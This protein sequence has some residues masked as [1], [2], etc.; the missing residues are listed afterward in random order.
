MSDNTNASVTPRS[1]ELLSRHRCGLLVVDVQEKLLGSIEGGRRVVW[2]IGRLLDAARLMGVPIIGT[3]Q[4]PQGL[5]PTVEEL[6]DRVGACAVK[7]TFSC[8]GCAGLLD[9]WVERSIDQV[10]VVGIEAHVCVLQTVMDLMHAG[11]RVYVP[12]DAV[13][14]RS[15]Q[16]RETALRR[17]EG[18]GAT[19]V[20][21][22]SVMF[23]WCETSAA[24][25]FKA[26]SSL[27]RQLPPAD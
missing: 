13:G 1:P 23:E 21:T 5:G 4:Y 9:A 18:G 25:E 12:V 19:L 8:G 3:E 10:L 26:I 16:D 14:S 11:F 6:R 22:E 17:M 27:V 24:A 20:S 15:V 2:N 7:R